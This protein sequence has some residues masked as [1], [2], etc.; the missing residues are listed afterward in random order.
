[1]S[2]FHTERY[3]SFYRQMLVAL[4]YCLHGAHES[5]LSRYLV[6]KPIHSRCFQ[7]IYN[8]TDLFHAQ[9]SPAK[10]QR[11]KQNPITHIY[12]RL[13]TPS[14]ATAVSYMGL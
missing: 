2:H 4:Y 10:D 11:S 7:L 9:S 5:L 14:Q 8:V 12:Y 6:S 3:D 13:S 1:M